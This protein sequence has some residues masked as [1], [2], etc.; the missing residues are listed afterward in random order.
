MPLCEADENGSQAK[1]QAQIIGFHCTWD[2][3]KYASMF[4]NKYCYAGCKTCKL[5]ENVIFCFSESGYRTNNSKQ[6][7]TADSHCWA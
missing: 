3:F 1:Q 2:E 5:K 4:E 6:K 7:Q